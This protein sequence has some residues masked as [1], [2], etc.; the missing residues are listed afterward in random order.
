MTY[1][2]ILI[3]DWLIWALNKQLDINR[4]W[5]LLGSI[6]ELGPKPPVQGNILPANQ[7]EDWIIFYLTTMPND[8]IL[9]LEHQHI[10]EWFAWLVLRLHFLLDMVKWIFLLPTTVRLLQYMKAWLYLASSCAW[11]Y[12]ALSFLKGLKPWIYCTYNNKI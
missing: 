6:N 8:N 10:N 7:C 11:E 3:E 9:G 1:T 5:H 2:T 12:W 4:P